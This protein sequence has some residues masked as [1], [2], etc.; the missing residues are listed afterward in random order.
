M[1][2]QPPHTAP[3]KPFPTWVIVLLC[4]LGAVVVFGGVLAALAIYGVRKYIANAKTAEARNAL[5]EI[6]RDAATAYE[7]DHALCASASSPVPSS[8]SMVRGVKYQSAPG[9]WQVDRARNAGFACLRFSMDMPQYYQ[10]SYT[11]SKTN[12][13]E[14]VAVAHGD[15]N[16]DGTLSTFRVRGVVK[17]GVL[18]IAPNIEETSPEE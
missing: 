12:P 5:G 13:D 16:G 18:E 9:E 3:S 4:V 10:Y 8:V 7:R 1:D 15:L 17:N 14:L 11:V 6:A 2:A